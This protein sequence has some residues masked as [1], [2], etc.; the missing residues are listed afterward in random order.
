MVIADV[1]N[2]EMQVEERDIDFMLRAYMRSYM[3]MSKNVV[4]DKIIFPMVSK[5]QNPYNPAEFVQ[6]EYVPEVSAKAKEIKEEGSTVPPTTEADEDEA[7]RRE[8]HFQEIKKL[9]Q[10]ID[11]AEE[12]VKEVEPEKPPVVRPID[13]VKGKAL[14]GEGTPIPPGRVPKKPVREVAP[15]EGS[16]DDMQPRS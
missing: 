9:A 7:D 14:E 3:F 4:P 12:A 13:K 2:K 8:E 1:E 10:E 11:K 15:G 5:V 6:V 16:L